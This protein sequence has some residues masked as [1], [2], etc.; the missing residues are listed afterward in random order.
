ML[1]GH[2]HASTRRR[3]AI[4]ATVFAFALVSAF[5]GMGSASRIANAQVETETDFDRSVVGSPVAEGIPFGLPDPADAASADDEALQQE[6]TYYG[7]LQ[8]AASGCPGIVDATLIECE[9]GANKFWV[10]ATPGQNLRRFFGQSVEIKGVLRECTDGENYLELNSI[11]PTRDCGKGEVESPGNVNL[12]LTAPVVA[13]THVPPNIMQNSTDGDLVSYWY[14]P[15]RDAW[16]Y[17]DLG[18]NIDPDGD[19]NP[20]KATFNEARLLWA[21]KHAVQYGL[22][23]FDDLRGRWVR[24]YQDNDGQPDETISFPRT[25]GRYVLLQLARSSDPNGDGFALREF[26]LYGV[27]T[28]N[29]ALGTNLQISS[30]VIPDGMGFNAVDGREDTAWM[31]ADKSLDPNPSIVVRFPDSVRLIEFRLLWDPAAM[32]AIFRVGFYQD[33]SPQVW[34]QQFVSTNH[35]QRLSWVVPILTEA[36]YLYTEEV[37]VNR[38]NVMLYDLQ[39]FGPDAGILG[40]LGQDGPGELFHP[41]GLFD[42]LR[43][44]VMSGLRSQGNGAVVV[45]QGASGRVFVPESE[46]ELDSAPA[47][48]ALDS[49]GLLPEAAWPDPR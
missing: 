42:R 38:D 49:I 8:S 17:F 25:Q 9:A 12:A 31:S 34:T 32:P 20:A 48:A 3:V 14:A 43:T 19:G 13:N 47:N 35:Q 45:P 39:L 37:G 5:L 2:R 4:I 10:L 7:R 21:H 22:Y 1:F 28:P 11:Q 24:F 40:V 30:E 18:P 6:V 41:H 29:L 46:A 16:I 33:G 36:F 44:R 27:E 26:E 23:V 15:G